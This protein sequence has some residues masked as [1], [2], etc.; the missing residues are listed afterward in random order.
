M[1][2]RWMGVAMR[3]RVWLELRSRGR[4]MDDEGIGICGWE[5]RC[6]KNFFLSFFFQLQVTS[7]NSTD[8]KNHTRN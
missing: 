3:M 4:D 5:W 7:T 6:G 2:K 1:G 8:C